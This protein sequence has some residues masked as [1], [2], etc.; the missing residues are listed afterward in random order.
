MLPPGLSALELRSIVEQAFLPQKCVCT[1]TSDQSLC[2]KL[3]NPQTDQVELFKADIPFDRVT[4]ARERARLVLELR[5]QP[6]PA[7]GE[8]HARAG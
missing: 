3:M 2:V 1:L 7:T 5:E 8:V 6:R 4:S